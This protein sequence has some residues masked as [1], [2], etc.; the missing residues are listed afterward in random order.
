VN[1]SSGAARLGGPGEYV[2]YAASKGAIDT[3]TVGLAKEEALADLDDKFAKRKYQEVKGELMQREIE[4]Y[5]ARID[6]Y[7]Q[8]MTLKFSFGVLIMGEQTP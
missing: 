1:L 4:V 3:M 6:R 8:D 5:A 2:D 7:P